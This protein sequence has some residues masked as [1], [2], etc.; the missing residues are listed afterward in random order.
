ML[1]LWRRSSSLPFK[2]TLNK[3]L[4]L[5]INEIF[6]IS[7]LDVLLCLSRG[8]NGQYDNNNTIIKD[9]NEGI[10]DPRLHPRLEYDTKI[11]FL[12]RERNCIDDNGLLHSIPCTLLDI[13]LYQL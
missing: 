8:K 6:K 3:K 1:N 2:H 7:W 12:L 11:R 10:N 9:D 5:N 4:G 13:C